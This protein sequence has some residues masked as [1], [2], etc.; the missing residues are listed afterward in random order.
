MWT[1]AAWLRSRT[2]SRITARFRRCGSKAFITGERH[3][4]NSTRERESVGNRSVDLDFVIEPT[5][6]KSNRKTVALQPIHAATENGGKVVK[7]PK[8]GVLRAGNLADMV[9]LTENPLANL[10]VLYGTGWIHVNDSTGAVERVGGIKYVM[11]DGILYDA[12]K[13]LRDVEDMVTAAKK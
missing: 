4:R 9:V 10:K 6:L 2:A 11:K 12:K 8:I 13:L 7:N 3:V 5:I 1:I